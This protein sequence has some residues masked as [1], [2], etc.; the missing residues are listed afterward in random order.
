MWVLSDEDNLQD[1][2]KNGRLFRVKR[3]S[4]PTDCE[5]KFEAIERSLD[6]L[7]EIAYRASLNNCEHFVTEIL[8]GKSTCGQLKGKNMALAMAVDG[9]ASKL[10]VKFFVEYLK[11]MP[12]TLKMVAELDSPMSGRFFLDLFSSSL[13]EGFEY[14]TTGAMSAMANEAY[15]LVKR[16]AVNMLSAAII[17]TIFLIG[18]TM[19]Q[20][21]LYKSGKI[22]AR[23]VARNF[24]QNASCVIGTSCG[25]FA[26]GLIAGVIFA[27]TGMAAPV[28]ITVG[29]VVGGL[30]G[31]LFMRAFGTKCLT[32]GP[33]KLSE[34]YCVIPKTY[35]VNL[36]NYLALLKCTLNLSTKPMSKVTIYGCRGTGLY[37][38]NSQFFNK[39]ME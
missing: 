28:G 23:V 15:G 38:I 4:Y 10:H 36:F 3:N 2:L 33:G 35:F 30:L 13:D 11:Q 32:N 24:L 6:R 8:T 18:F 19:Y 34:S 31:G 27:L 9:I 22:T 39:D 5:G 21:F 16:S 26:G 20:L 7:G 12:S 17:E 25:T 14:F 29:N 37:K 1:D